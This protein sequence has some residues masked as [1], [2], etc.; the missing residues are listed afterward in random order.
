MIKIKLANLMREK[1]KTLG[2]LFYELIQR[3]KFP[4]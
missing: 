3:N 1:K 2:I 4:Q